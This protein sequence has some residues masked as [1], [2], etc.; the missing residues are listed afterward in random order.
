MPYQGEMETAKELL[1]LH[2]T[3]PP[4]WQRIAIEQEDPSVSIQQERY[5]QQGED[6]A[7]DLLSLL[8]LCTWKELNLKEPRGRV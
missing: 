2:V 5:H 6:T 8:K 4:T 3:P 7:K 1:R